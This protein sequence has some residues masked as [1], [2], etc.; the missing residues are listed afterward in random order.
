MSHVAQP[1]PDNNNL[2]SK[3]RKIREALLE[4]V[5][6]DL[7]GPL[8]GE[9]EELDGRDAH[10]RDY[11]LGSLAPQNTEINPAEDEDFATA[12]GDDEDTADAGTEGQG[13]PQLLPS[14]IG[15]TFIVPEHV[16]EIAVTARW[17]RYDRLTSETLTNDDGS[18]RKSWQRTPMGGEPRL[19]QLREWDP[20]N[21]DDYLLQPA[22]DVAPNVVVTGRIRKR[23]GSWF[24]TL[25]LKNLQQPDDGD[26]RYSRWLYQVGMEVEAVD[27]AAIFESRQDGLRLDG[28]VED[29]EAAM[30][31]RDIHEFATGHGC[32]VEATVDPMQS[33]RARK[34]KTVSIP[35]F[36]VPRT[37][38]PGPDD[39]EL[40]GDVE[41]DMK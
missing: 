3:P 23:A 19:L 21:E 9:D 17:G 16:R 25:F 7:H 39:H 22:P 37:D 35:R 11:I 1:L 38:A 10:P 13:K 30:L 2:T 41:L 24:V 40:L 33:D 31:Y 6:R 29:R 36:E 12:D 20:E 14:S 8:G 27:S 32:A 15:M 5:V 26:N 4:R 18:P 28:E 34:V